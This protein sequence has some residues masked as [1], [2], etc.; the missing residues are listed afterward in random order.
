MPFNDDK[1]GMIW[2]TRTGDPIGGSRERQMLDAIGGADSF[3]TRVSQNPDGSTTIM[4]TKNGMPHFETV[5]PYRIPAT[6]IVTHYLF[7][8]ECPTDYLSWFSGS[9][10]IPVTSVAKYVSFSGAAYATRAEYTYATY[11]A[12]YSSS[13]TW[14]GDA[15]SIRHNGFEN[16][17]PS[18]VASSGVV[19]FSA[20]LWTRGAT[21]AVH[22]GAPGSLCN[23]IT[24]AKA[25]S[26]D[27]YSSTSLVFDSLQYSDGYPNT[28]WQIGFVEGHV[29]DKTSVHAAFCRMNGAIKEDF[30]VEARMSAW[31]ISYLNSNSRMYGCPLPTTQD[32]VF[33]TLKNLTTGVASTINLP[34]V[35]AGGFAK[36]TDPSGAVS[37]PLYQSFGPRP[38]W[39]NVSPDGT[40]AY[41]RI[42]GGAYFDTTTGITE[43]TEASAIASIDLVSGTM[44][45]AQLD[46]IY[47]R[48]YQGIFCD[49]DEI[50]YVN[51]PSSIQYDILSVGF[52]ASGVRIVL[53]MR[54]FGAGGSST[55][56]FPKEAI[57]ENST[58]LIT[59]DSSHPDA[60]SISVMCAYADI[61]NR[62]YVMEVTYLA[63]ATAWAETE[64]IVMHNGAVLKKYAYTTTFNSYGVPT[65]VTMNASN[66]ASSGYVIGGA[67][68]PVTG[69]NVPMV[70]YLDMNHVESKAYGPANVAP[71]GSY[72]MSNVVASVSKD[73]TKLAI[74]I[75]LG[76]LVTFQTSFVRPVIN[77]VITLAT[78]TEETFGSSTKFYNRLHFEEVVT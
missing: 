32:T 3:R 16:L 20:A 23:F 55:A 46:S 33:G 9:T 19:A 4:R 54:S 77:R 74:S 30:Y 67:A 13:V 39:M 21:S 45:I 10:F 8:I 78:G 37:Y 17:T 52:D 69:T 26:N 6:T 58:A 44:A 29:S 70:T 53:S 18:T 40:T 68:L 38:T 43:L 48:K 14:S 28:P 66:T 42:S 27:P 50:R 5:S 60:A 47:L 25:T 35:P 51:M 49:S 41:T 24:W 34:A 65:A 75:L 76:R 57:Y 72:L 22:M 31:G 62:L 2:P 63:G 7:G 11:Y 71:Y 1:F 59:R 12:D 61:S 36:Y 64:L 56:T 15:G 73:K